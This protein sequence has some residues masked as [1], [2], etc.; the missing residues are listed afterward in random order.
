M[1]CLPIA[2]C[3][4]PL[5][6]SA[7]TESAKDE[8]AALRNIGSLHTSLRENKKDK[9]DKKD[10]KDKDDDDQQFLLRA[11]RSFAEAARSLERSYGELQ[12]EVGRLRRELG[13]S[14]AGLEQSLKENRRMHA[15][16]DRILESLPC[17]VLV[18]SPAGAI[19]HLNP[20]AARL[21][22]LPAKRSSATARCLADVPAVAGQLLERS[23][24]SE[25]APEASLPDEYGRWLA[26][27]HAVVGDSEGEQG[28]SVFI[29]QDVT[30][31]KRL[32]QAEQK[33][34]REQALA[35]MSAVLAHEIRNPLGSLELFAGLLAESVGDAESKRWIGH[36][37][38]GL[39]TLAA[40]ANNV[41]H[42]HSL[43][44]SELAPVDL[45]CLLDWANG[46]L[47]P[48]ACQ[49][50]LQLVSEH[51]LTGVEIAGDRHRLEQVLLN[52]ALNAMR[53]TPE[54]GSIRL[55][56]SRTDAGVAITVSDSGPGIPPECGDKIFEPGFSTR[57]SSP[58]LGLAVCRKIVE[59][60]G[61]TIAVE[62]PPGPG[63]AFTVR[64]PFR[65]ESS[66]GASR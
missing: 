29:L 53:A 40:T 38:A 15:H 56:G 61:G 35:E 17:G 37:Q 25:C 46:F 51:A 65:P 32:E 33:L 26:A 43:P 31:R 5:I 23:R 34:R 55:S 16:L 57:P 24:H 11:F 13:T 58:G 3:S 39:R 9:K 22:G 42:F 27:R 18:A 47:A 4:L 60:H 21:L 28:S 52:L 62:S 12:L 44:E 64:L 45:G 49:A 6:A 1:T 10:W 19:T 50:G 63:A 7:A 41:L 36:V 30:E 8:D 48:L 20:E 14:R 59:Q 66:G 2:P 54:G